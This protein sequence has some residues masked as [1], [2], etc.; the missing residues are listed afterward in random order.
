MKSK[1]VWNRSTMLTR[2]MIAFVLL[3]VGA[4]AV[5]QSNQTPTSSNDGNGQRCSNR[6]L[7]G[8][9]GYSSNGQVLPAPGLSF[10]FTSTGI[11]T[12]DGNGNVSWIEHTVI[13]GAQQG[14]DW[15][16][17]TSGTYTVNSNCTATAVV[18]TPNSPVPLNLFFSL[19]QQGKQLYSVVNGNA[20]TGVWTRLN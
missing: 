13:G 5:A 3:A 19:V 8:S 18:V 17:S 20:I 16:S 1:S 10:P 7:N 2:V 11:A 15:T 12:F 9:Y 14:A 6:T 4:S